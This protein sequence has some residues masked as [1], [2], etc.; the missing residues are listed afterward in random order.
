MNYSKLLDENYLIDNS[1]AHFTSGVNYSV[2]ELRTINGLSDLQL[3]NIHN[4]KKT[5]K[6]SE[7]L[8]NI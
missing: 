5:F 4:I 8:N 2:N 6:K 1:G 7:I 3:K